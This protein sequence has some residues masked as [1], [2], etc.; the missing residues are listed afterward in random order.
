MGGAWAELHR[1]AAE[2]GAV[3]RAIYWSGSQ[4]PLDSCSDSSPAL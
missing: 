2:S 3:R 4:K 1:G